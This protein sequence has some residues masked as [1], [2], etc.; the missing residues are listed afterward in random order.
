MSETQQSREVKA[1]KNQLMFRAVN[2][3][4]RE[5]SERVLHQAAEID[6]ACECNDPTCVQSVAIDLDEFVRLD[7]STN[8]FVV[9]PGHEDP[10][11]EDVVDT[12]Q[13]FVVVSKR[14]AGADFIRDQS[15]RTGR[16]GRLVAAARREPADDE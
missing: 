2:Q 5:V 7:R 13:R 12:H 9:L 10:T 6:F 8:R 14:G 3:Q 11:V 16:D 15:R 4:I 1:A